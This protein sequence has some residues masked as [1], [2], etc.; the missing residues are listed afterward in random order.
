MAPNLVTLTGWFI[1]VIDL[2]IIFAFD[3]TM[4]KVLPLWVYFISAFSIWFYQTMDAVDGKQAR[5]TGTSG[6]LGQLFDHGCDAITTTFVVAIFLQS[7]IL[8]TEPDL[9]SMFCLYLSS[10][11]SI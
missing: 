4:S 10:H 11:V 1:I 7:A 2:V 3:T 5:R 6:P 9:Q 8:G